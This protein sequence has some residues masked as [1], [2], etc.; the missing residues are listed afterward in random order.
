VVPDQTTT[1][2]LRKNGSRKEIRDP[3]SNLVAPDESSSGSKRNSFIRNYFPPNSRLFG[4]SFDFVGGVSQDI[5]DLLNLAF[6]A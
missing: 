3:F 6:V 4:D 2:V 5:A 1:L